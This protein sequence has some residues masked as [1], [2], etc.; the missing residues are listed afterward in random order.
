MTIARDNFGRFT[1]GII[2]WN[3]GGKNVYS[4][5]VLQKMSDAKKGKRISPKTE[6]IKG[7]MPWNKGL[8]GILKP[9]K[10]SYKKGRILLKKIEKN[11][12]N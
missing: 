6:F 3:K 4:K 9:N 7:Y 11:R 8:K 10:T 1:K 5:E 12:K 2:P